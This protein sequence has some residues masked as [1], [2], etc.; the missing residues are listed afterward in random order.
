MGKVN[1][2]GKLP[3]TFEKAWADTPSLGHY[4]GAKGTVDYAED[5]L[6]GYRWFD[7]KGVAPS[8]RSGSASA[9]RPSTTTR[10]TSPRRRTATGPSP[11]T[12][13]TTARRRGAEVSGGLREPARDLQGHEA[14]ARATRRASAARRPRA[15]TRRSR[16]TVVLDRKAFSHYDEKKGDWVV[17]PGTYTI[18]VGSSSRTVPDSLRGAL[19]VGAGPRWTAGKPWSP[20]ATRGAGTCARGRASG[21]GICPARSSSGRPSPGAASGLG[22]GPRSSPAPAPRPSVKRPSM[23]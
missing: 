5:I 6:V 7:T 15:P 14:R 20:S 9:T 8:S 4:P 3:V 2:S 19:A 12:S 17:E 11:S 21:W 22:P 23:P 18:E 1:P 10:S 13:R 16:F